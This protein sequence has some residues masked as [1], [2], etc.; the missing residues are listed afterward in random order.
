[1][2]VLI[3]SDRFGDLSVQAVDSEIHLGDADRRGIFLL[4]V[5]NDLLSGVFTLMFDKVTR[6][7]EHASRP[8]CRIK[9]G[10]VIWFNYIDDGL[11]ER[12]WREELDIV[13]RFLDGKFGKNIF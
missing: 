11:H 10:A 9:H 8:T 7:H 2:L 5:E 4:S 12:G 1:I 3:V 13:V 6:L